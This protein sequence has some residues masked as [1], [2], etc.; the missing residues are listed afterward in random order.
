MDRVHAS[1]S[2]VIVSWSASGNT[3]RLTSPTI[4]LSPT[5]SRPR[6]ALIRGT[7]F[8]IEAPPVGSHLLRLY[9]CHSYSDTETL[10]SSYDSRAPVAGTITQLAATGAEL[11]KGD[12]IATIAPVS[13]DAVAVLLAEH[14]RINALTHGV[15]SRVN[16]GDVLASLDAYSTMILQVGET[17]TWQE[18]SWTADFEPV[19]ADPTSTNLFP[20]YKFASAG[21]PV[22]VASLGSGEIWSVGAFHSSLTQIASSAKADP[23]CSLVNEAAFCNRN[24]PLFSRLVD[25]PWA[26]KVL[27]K[28]APFD[29]FSFSTLGERIIEGPPGQVFS[30]QGGQGSGVNS[31]SRI[32]RF[33]TE[34]GTS[35]A[36]AVPE[37]DNQVYGLAWDGTRIWFAEARIGATASVLGSFKPSTTPCTTHVDYG[38]PAEVGSLAYCPAATPYGDGC[39]TKLTIPGVNIVHLAIAPDPPSE[40]IE[41]WATEATSQGINR[42]VVDTNTNTSSVTRFPTPA[43]SRPRQSYWPPS[44]TRCRI[45]ADKNHVYFSESFDTDLVRMTRFPPVGADCTTLTTSGKNPCMTELH[46][47]LRTQAA[48]NAVELHDGRLYFTVDNG[49]L[50]YA[51]LSSWNGGVLYTGMGGDL[52]DS[53]RRDVGPARYG[54]LT[55][56]REGALAVADYGRRQLVILRPRR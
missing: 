42:I 45:V 14:G 18:T 27:R 55:F 34:R 56:T 3:Y 4:A 5:A 12:R 40:S 36:W 8:T 13:G 38:N 26:G 51:A 9:S 28:T 10:C 15:G 54:G 37:A 50:G 6:E 25:T 43:P 29:G 2:G 48:L 17:S 41:L 47:E 11:R 33:D 44:S 7:G 20:V 1:G 19:G 46:V 39:I 16:E 31:H 24:I 30:S 21:Y 22:D 32:V 52:V 35:C 49:Q 53:T 23:H